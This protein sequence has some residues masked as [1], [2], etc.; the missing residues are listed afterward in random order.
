MALKNKTKTN[1]LVAEGIVTVDE[2]KE[3]DDDDWD[4]WASNCKRPD[5][6]SHPNNPALLIMVA[7]Y[8]LSAKSLKRLKTAFK[9]VRYDDLVVILLTATNIKWVVMDNFI[10]QRKVTESKAK[11]TTPDIPERTKNM[12]AAKWDDSVCLRLASVWHQEVNVEVSVG[13]RKGS[14]CNTSYIGDQLSPLSGCWIHPGRT[15]H[16]AVPHASTL[17]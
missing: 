14:E 17:S 16:A 4:Q 12:T 11:A 6:I 3:R 13:K 7:P 5:K 9:L 10:T 1:S 15:S 2:L 8:S